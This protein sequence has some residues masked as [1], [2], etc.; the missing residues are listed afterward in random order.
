MTSGV[1][2]VLAPVMALF[3]VIATIFLARTIETQARRNT[4]TAGDEASLDGHESEVRGIAYVA[5]SG[6][7]VELGIVGESPKLSIQELKEDLDRWPVG[8]PLDENFHFAEPDDEVS[9]APKPTKPAR[10]RDKQ[11]GV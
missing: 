5:K 6:R 3:S 7:G 9:P 8:D 2:L 4:S 11:K 1:L 10:S